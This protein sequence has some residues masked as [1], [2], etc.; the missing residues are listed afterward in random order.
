[1]RAGMPLA[2]HPAP[3]PP[4]WTSA[5]VHAGSDGLARSLPTVSPMAFTAGLARRLGQ[6]FEA[7]AVE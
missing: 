4:L 5:P 2:L 7:A 1:M 6:G 3:T